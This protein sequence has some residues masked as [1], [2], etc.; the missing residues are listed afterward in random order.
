MGVDDLKQMD[1][2][3]Q[4]APVKKTLLQKLADNRAKQR[5]TKEHYKEIYRK[6][7]GITKAKAIKKR[8]RQEAYE[9]HRPTRKQKI[10]SV[11]KCFE[12]LG[13]CAAGASQTR[14]RKTGG[15]KKGKQ[16]YT[17]VGGKAYPVAGS[18]KGGSQPRKSKKKRSGFDL[19][20]GFVDDI[21]DF[22]F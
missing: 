13:L 18:G 22:D 2:H 19:D 3:I 10:Y 20:L 15:K 5:A 11:L 1:K 12:N 21:G 14:S 17:I 4:K 7:Y 9:K 6:E 8:A 16:K